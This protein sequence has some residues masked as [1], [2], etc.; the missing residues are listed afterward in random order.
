MGEQEQETGLLLEAAPPILQVLPINHSHVRSK[1][2][3]GFFFSGYDGR[4]F[5]EFKRRME[6]EM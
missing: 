3:S 1:K 4:H 2:K 5:G 6:N